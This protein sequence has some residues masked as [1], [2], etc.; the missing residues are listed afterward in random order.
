MARKCRNHGED[1][2]MNSATRR[3][4]IAASVLFAAAVLSAWHS[5]AHAAKATEC[6]KIGICYCVNDEFKPTIGTKVDKLGQVI[7]EQRKAG[8]VVGY[9][10]L[11]LTSGGNFDVNKEVAGSAKDA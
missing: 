10:S 3:F 7:A 8:K 9:L 4:V 2:K 1:S 6:A 11:P 5:P